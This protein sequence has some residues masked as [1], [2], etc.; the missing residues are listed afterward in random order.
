M[1]VYHSAG[2][3][4]NANSLE[5]TSIVLAPPRNLENSLVLLL[6]FFLY[7]VNLIQLD[8]RSYGILQS[9]GITCVLNSILY[10]R[11]CTKL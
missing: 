1:A 7:N 9:Y 11:S 10:A 5:R 6:L 4:I 2:T 3:Y 8:S